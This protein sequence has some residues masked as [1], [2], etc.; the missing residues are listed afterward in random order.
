MCN[1]ILEMS[2]FMQNIIVH[3]CTHILQPFVLWVFLGYFLTVS[4]NTRNIHS[5]FSD[6]LDDLEKIGS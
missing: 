3:L 2:C 6:L 1:N 5:H 4:N